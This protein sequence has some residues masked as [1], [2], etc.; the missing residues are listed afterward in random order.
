[1]FFA[2]DLSFFRHNAPFSSDLQIIVSFYLNFAIIFESKTKQQK[3]SE[4]DTKNQ[5]R[6]TFRNLISISTLV[7]SGVMRDNGHEF[8]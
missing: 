6:K 4:K 5:V 8:H 2:F 1:M 7:T 3:K